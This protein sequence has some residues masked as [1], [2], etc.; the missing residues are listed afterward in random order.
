MISSNTA[1]VKG[2][3]ENLTPGLE[4]MAAWWPALSIVIVAFNWFLIQFIVSTGYQALTPARGALAL[5][6]I[7]MAPFLGTMIRGITAHLVPPMAGEGRIS[8]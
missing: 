4:R 3:D 2:E 1:I 8:R 5:T 6:F 7:V